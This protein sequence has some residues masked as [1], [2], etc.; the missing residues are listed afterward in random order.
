M[1]NN[2]V[3][4]DIANYKSRY[5]FKNKIYR[6]T[7]SIVWGVFGATTPRNLFKRWKRF[8]LKLFGAKIGK[9]VV[10]ESGAKIFLP[11]NLI[12]K[13]YSK[14]ASRTIIHNVDT[15]TIEEE[16]VVS[17]GAF[18]CAGSHDIERADWKQITAPITI[19]KNAWVAV[20][21]F[22]AMGVTVG[23]GAVV[24]ARA[25][26]FKDVEPWTVVGG[27]PAKFIKRREIKEHTS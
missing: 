5:G 17:Q 19:K 15:V 14:L 8:L 11:Y 10:V 16:A 25:C 23:E 13:D 18:I 4:A 1:E 6:L 21:A 22:V 7:W 24:G 3:K 9:G 20:D 12:M 26:V 27:N 2:T